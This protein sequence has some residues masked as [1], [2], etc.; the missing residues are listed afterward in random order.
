MIKTSRGRPRGLCHAIECG[1]PP[2]W[3][4]PVEV[5]ERSEF[6]QVGLADVNADRSAGKASGR[7][8]ENYCKLAHTQGRAP[9]DTPT[10]PY[11]TGPSIVQR[12]SRTVK[13]AAAVKALN[14][15]IRANPVTDYFCSTRESCHPARTR[16]RTTGC[17]A[18]DNNECSR[19]NAAG[20]KRDEH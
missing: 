7:R 10:S 4:S 3:P 11:P 9:H 20:E 5:R 6:G 1:V 16:G 15:R 17:N 14:A 18:L 8:V 13:M 19:T 2:H 12:E